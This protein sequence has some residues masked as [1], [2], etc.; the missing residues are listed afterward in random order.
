MT[1][2]DP[3]KDRVCEVAILRVEGG[4]VVERF[5]TL[6]RPPVRVKS[7]A[8]KVH[9]ISDAELAGAPDF[10]QV[11]G[12]VERLLRGAVVVSH[13]V[14]FDLGYLFREFEALGL[15]LEVPVT[16]DTLAIARRLFA[17][18]RN[19]LETVAREL[20]VEAPLAH[21]ALADAWTTLGVVR[22]MLARLDPRGVITVSEV[23]E[24]L[25]ALAPNAPRRLRQQQ[26]LREAWRERRTVWIDYQS[27]A[28]VTAGVTT[29]EVAVWLLRPPRVQGWCYLRQGPRVFRQ[30]RM[31]DVRRGERSYEIP[32]FEPKI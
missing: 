8:R 15:S 31:R 20:G 1:G 25:G 5:Q 22:E 11:R 27:S 18:P 13:N 19:N 24:L 17:F 29:R 32:D 9:G 14:E 4:E 6:V 7:S 26:L 16:L 12:D 3:N 23:E 2:L 21:R 28:S 10:F 30:D